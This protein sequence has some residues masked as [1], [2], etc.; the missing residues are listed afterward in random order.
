MANDE[1]HV[2]AILKA[3]EGQPKNTS[4]ALSEWGH[5]NEQLATIAD[6][7]EVLTAVLVSANGGNFGKVSSSPR[8]ETS[9]D[10]VRDR[11]RKQKHRQIVDRVLRRGAT[12][13]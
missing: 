13:E 6:R 11:L 1:E 3:T 10:V 12:V 7:L 5:S 8:P 9:F 2:E 4:P